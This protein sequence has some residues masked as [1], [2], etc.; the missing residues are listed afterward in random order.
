MKTSFHVRTL[1]LI[2]G[3][4][5]AV[6]AASAA[7]FSTTVTNFPVWDLEGAYTASLTS[8]SGNGSVTFFLVHDADG[9]LKCNGSGAYTIV[10]RDGGLL[11]LTVDSL[12]AAGTTQLS[13]GEAA[14]DLQLVFTGSAAGPSRTR[15]FIGKL[16]V[17]AHVDPNSHVIAGE[18]SGLITGG[19]IDEPIP[20]QAFSV[21]L[22][23]N[24][25]GAWNL[26]LAYEPHGRNL[27]V[28][29]AKVTFDTGRTLFLAGQGTENAR[30][31]AVSFDL[32][33][34]RWPAR[35]PMAC[36]LSLTVSATGNVT[37]VSGELL[38][39]RLL[40]QKPLPVLIY[41]P[42]FVSDQVG[43]TVLP[44]FF[45]PVDI[46]YDAPTVKPLPVQIYPPDPVAEPPAKSVPVF[47]PPV[48]IISE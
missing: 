7:T 4:W 39:Q 5:L 43:Q 12:T 48:D 30:T 6:L 38:G 32:R 20:R 37:N 24:Q 33:G 1:A 34:P 18:I 13:G 23:L 8:G 47:F 41:P 35:D 44:V 14:L 19:G 15:R 36:H 29:Q 31:G 17:Q 46:V 16:R 11:V 22:A 2:A 3:C 28:S 21:P 10:D 40:F 25:S 45:P 27:A 26:D 42:D 9:N